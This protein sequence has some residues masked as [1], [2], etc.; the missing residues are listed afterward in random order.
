MKAA[1]LFRRKVAF[2]M[3]RGPTGYRARGVVLL[4]YRSRRSMEIQPFTALR[5]KY[6]IMAIF[7]RMVM[8]KESVVKAI[9]AVRAASGCQHTS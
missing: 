4:K 2:L 7:R 3:D 5:E 9:G 1:F 8:T 6:P